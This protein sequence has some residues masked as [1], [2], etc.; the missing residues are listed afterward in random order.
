MK[1][2]THILFISFILMACATKQDKLHLSDF[3]I[4]DENGITR[5]VVSKNGDIKMN[6]ELMGVIKSD[7][8]INDQNGEL[9]ATITADNTLQNKDVQKLVLID[10]NGQIDNGSGLFIEWTEDG[11]FLK[12]AEKTGITIAPVN[13]KSFQTASAILCLYLSF[14]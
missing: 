5:L 4:K 2:F 10:E 12:G 11:E 9:V 13:K 6:D 1:H 8:N 14:N 7:G 3:E